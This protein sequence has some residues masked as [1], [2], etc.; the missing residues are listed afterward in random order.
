MKVKEGINQDRCSYAVVTNNPGISGAY[1][2]TE[3]SFLL[4]LHVIKVR[5]EL[6]SL[7]FFLQNPGWKSSH[8]REHGIVLKGECWACLAGTVKCFCVEVP[9]CWSELS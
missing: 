3:G 5:W 8:Q 2:K 9:T 7:L 1:Y 6:C 4:L